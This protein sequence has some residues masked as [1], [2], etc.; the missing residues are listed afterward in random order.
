[1]ITIPWYFLLAGVVVLIGLVLIARRADKEVAHLKASR[2]QA[3]QE[4]KQAYAQ[5]HEDGLNDAYRR[6]D[7]MG[8][9]ANSAYDKGYAAG[10][11]DAVET[12]RHTRRTIS[13]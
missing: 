4:G 8:A 13:A 10:Q 5:G 2:D 1:M 6:V 3:I 7:G 9:N 12:R 11:R